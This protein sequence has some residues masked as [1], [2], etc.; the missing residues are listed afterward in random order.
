MVA[1]GLSAMVIVITV[2]VAA[3][4]GGGGGSGGGGGGE[5]R[6]EGR[7]GGGGC[8]CDSMGFSITISILWRGGGDWT[9]TGGPV[10]AAWCY[11]HVVRVVVPAREPVGRSQTIISRMI[12]RPR[13]FGVE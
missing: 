5:G 12:R 13:L 2:V 10:G 1:V 7:G 8:G 6:G 4:E 11:S 9:S 3:H